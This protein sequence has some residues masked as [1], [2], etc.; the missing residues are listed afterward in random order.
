[1]SAETQFCGVILAAGASSRMGRDKA[2]L[3]W[4][5]NSTSDSLL[6]AAI[7]ALQ[8]FTSAVIVV[9]GK[10]IRNLAPI[11]AACQA[12]LVHNPAPERGQF[13]SFQIGLRAAV[14]RGFSAVMLAPVDCPPLSAASLEN[15]RTAFK[16]ATGRGAWAVAPEQNGRRGH[17]LLASRPLIDAFLEAPISSNARVVKHAHAARFEFVAVPDPLLTVDLNTPEQYAAAQ[18]REDFRPS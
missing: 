2:M 8:P 1:M 16:L 9:A 18:T 15:L 6:S 10:N 14:D 3:P 4:P 7:H 13:S 17:P 11:V 12:E 5:S